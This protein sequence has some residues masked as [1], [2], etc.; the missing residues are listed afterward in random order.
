MAIEDDGDDDPSN[1]DLIN[2][3]FGSNR[4]VN[5]FSRIQK[6]RNSTQIETAGWRRV[7]TYD[8]QYHQVI[9]F[10]KSSYKIWNNFTIFIKN[11]NL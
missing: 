10:F 1:A 6:V 3:D 11:L 8:M 2:K 5:S 9:L 4:A 7:G